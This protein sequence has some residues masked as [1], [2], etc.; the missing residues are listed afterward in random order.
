MSAPWSLSPISPVL[1]ATIACTDTTQAVSLGVTLAN[2]NQYADGPNTVIV[3]NVGTNEAFVA[4]GKSD[5]TVAAGGT[6]TASND[7]GAC[8]PAGAIVSFSANLPNETHAAGICRTGLTTTLRL[9]R[10]YGQ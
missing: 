10:G 7:G 3:S 5:V 1:N 6:I 8:V 4:F 2:G 9:T